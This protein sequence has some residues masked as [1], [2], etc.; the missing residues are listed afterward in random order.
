M[1]FIFYKCLIAAHMLG[2]NGSLS[3]KL[4]TSGV[5]HSRPSLPKNSGLIALHILQVPDRRA[6]A[7]HQR[8]SQ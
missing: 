2:I 7:R 3:M 5:M 8:H 6:Q 1:L 4:Q